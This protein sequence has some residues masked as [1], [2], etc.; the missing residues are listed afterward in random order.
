MKFC[1]SLKLDPL[2]RPW[3]RLRCHILVNT[4]TAF[5]SKKQS[6]TKLILCDCTYSMWLYLPTRAV[7]N[8]F[9]HWPSQQE[10]QF[11]RLTITATIPKTISA[12]PMQIKLMNPILSQSEKKGKVNVTYKLKN[13]N[14]VLAWKNSANSCKI[15]SNIS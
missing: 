2:Q 14:G 9:Q 11:F 10:Q 8:F 3:Y 5:D 12:T 1:S 7:L 15:Q 13:L 6:Q 4:N